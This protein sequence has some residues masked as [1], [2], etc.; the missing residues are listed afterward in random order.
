LIDVVH[1][2]LEIGLK[3]LTVYGFS[4]E[5]WKRP[6]GEL[7]ALMHELPEQMGRL[8]DD[9]PPLDVRVRWAGL[10]FPLPVEVIGELVAAERATQHCSALILT[11][12]VNYGGRAEITAAATRLAHE[13][14]AGRIS[15]ASISEHTFARYLHVP[16]LPDVD[17]L[18][19]TGG[20]QRT[21]N[22]LPWQ[23][24]YAELVFL[25][26]L[27]PDVDRRDLWR[28]MEQ[29]AARDRRYGSVPP[30]RSARPLR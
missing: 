29:Y 21:S 10:R 24:A 4:T 5:N 30:P 3:H 20:D 15:A 22:F 28:A 14:A 12:C 27:W 1:G 16:D 17:M 13:A 25:D 7:H 9:C 26:T 23:A 18:L 19:R 2:A 8:K 11:A 6:V